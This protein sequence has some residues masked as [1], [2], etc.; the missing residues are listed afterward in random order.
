MKIRE[1]EA[2]FNRIYPE[3]RRCPWDN[4]GLLVCPDRDREVKRVI[5]CLDVTF[6]VIEEAIQK[7]CELIVS[8]HPL[9]FSP[10]H[11]INEDSAVGQKILLLLTNHISLISLHTRLDAS[12]GGLCEQ[13]AKMLG[14]LP[15]ENTVLLPEEPFI[16][17]IG[18]L[19]YKM[20]PENF[21]ET[22]SRALS[23][24]VRMYSS[25]LDVHRVGF[26]CGSGKDLVEPAL[27][28]GAD[29]F[30]GG[31]I[32]YHTAQSAVEMGMTVIDCGH[33]ASENMAPALLRKVLFSF[34]EQLEIFPICEPIGGE[35]VDFS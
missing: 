1:I 29:A 34:S 8:H 17:G 30:V 6:N 31:D 10:I 15:E 3:E 33:H 19:S 27:C 22:V 21:A 20:S 18:S 13:F 14:I 26:C 35:I 28:H 12:P 24:P 5:T 16:G 23:A 4:D 32:P 25:G 11:R 9:I 7:G 2:N